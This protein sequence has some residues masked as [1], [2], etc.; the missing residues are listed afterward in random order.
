[1]CT[2]TRGRALEELII[3]RN[4]L[5]INEATDVPIFETKRDRSWTDLTRC[6]NI[7][8]QNIR[9]WTCGEEESCADHKIL[10]FDMETMVADGNSTHLPRKRYLTNADNWGTLSTI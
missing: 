3:S 8:A 4:L 2:N 10:L 6:N 5:I 9:G 1:M 7:L